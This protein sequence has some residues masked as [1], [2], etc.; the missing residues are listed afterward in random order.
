ML[1]RMCIKGN[2]PQLLVGLKICTTTLEINLGI[3]Q[4]AVNS[5]IS[6]YSYITPLHIPKGHILYLT[7]RVTLVCAKESYL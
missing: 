3:S 5:S 1:T 7:N 4:T 6:K 2:T